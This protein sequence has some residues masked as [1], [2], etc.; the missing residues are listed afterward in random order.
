MPTALPLFLFC[1]QNCIAVKA[2][3]GQYVIVVVSTGLQL[4]DKKTAA[5]QSD[6]QEPAA[7]L[8]SDGQLTDEAK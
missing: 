6:D 3:P 7:L 5:S 4:L 8:D 1:W 2:P